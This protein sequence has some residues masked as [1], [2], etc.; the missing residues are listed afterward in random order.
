MSKFSEYRISYAKEIIETQNN[1]R[2]ENLEYVIFKMYC[3]YLVVC[4]FKN[5]G[6]TIYLREQDKIMRY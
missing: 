5:I 6:E 3:G 1:L 2:E 4:G